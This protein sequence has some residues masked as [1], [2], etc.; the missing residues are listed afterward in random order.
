[1]AQSLFLIGGGRKSAL[2]CVLGLSPGITIEVVSLLHFLLQEFKTPGLGSFKL[3]S[4]W[5]AA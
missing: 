4:H 5:Y 1:M 2:A 3:H